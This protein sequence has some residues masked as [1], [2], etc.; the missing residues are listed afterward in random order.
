MADTET[1]DASARTVPAGSVR[2]GPAPTLTSQHHRITPGLVL[3]ALSIV[4]VLLFTAWVV[5]S[6]P[7]AALGAFHAYFV[8]PLALLLAVLLVPAG[9]RL[10][11]RTAAAIDAPWWTVIAT[12]AV[13][14]GFAWFAA[15]TH[16]QQIILRRDAGAYAQIG[17]WLAHHPRLTAVVPS[18]SFGPGGTDL[19]YNSAAFYERS[20]TIIPQFMTGWPTALAGAWWVGGWNGIFMLPAITGGCGILAISGLAARVIGAR[21]APLVALLTACAWPVL[22]VS[23]T[24]YSEPLAFLF[25]AGGMCLLTDLVM[26]DSTRDVVR[27]PALVAGLLLS[28]GELV[29]VDFDVDFAL[30]LPIIAWLWVTRRPGTLP[31][32]V[33]AAIGTA[34]GLADALFVTR[35]YIDL[36]LSSVELMV[37]LL[38][39]MA[40]ASIA[41]AL[42]ARRWGTA[43]AASPRGRRLTR[44]LP[45]AGVLVVVAVAAALLVRP[46]LT[47]DQS[48][49]DGGVRLFIANAQK[50]LGLPI[51]NNRGYAEQSLWWVSWYLGW[52]L[53]AAAGVG[54]AALVFRVLKGVE[55]RW[56]PAL[57][58]YGGSSLLTLLR[59]G[60][61]PDHPW[62][63]RR[64]VVE[65]LPGLVLFAS[66]T[67][68]R[69][70]R[71]VRARLSSALPAAGDQAPGT[72][73]AGRV[74]RPRIG[75]AVA[76]HLLPTATLAGLIALL[77]VPTV[78]AT[79]PVAAKRTEL[80]QLDAVETVCQALQPNDSV[81]MLD[82]LWIPNVRAQCR[83][84]VAQLP[85]PSHDAILKA[86]ASIR[87][88][89]RTPVIAATDAD[90]LKGQGF[91]P[92]MVVVLNTQ[93]D[94]QQLVKRPTTT[95]PSKVEFWLAR[96]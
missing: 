41:G 28:S 50:R 61:T 30:I 10:V 31:F 86:A 80:G 67:I 20:G 81:L 69:V 95:Q 27:R 11:S 26:A 96:P 58:V 1:A 71:A 87:S 24:T 34:L 21:W 42:F 52:P 47:V 25:L 78:R 77:L 89:G 93:Q 49:R 56:L 33:G 70:T 17:Y 19:A 57:L 76:V 2:S 14:V 51:E 83:L 74:R 29:R 91:T 37:A 35:P 82:S 88:V 5:A 40:G 18:S 38:V 60:I 75:R 4:P 59:P 53:I 23:Q 65:V 73:P 85:D 94:D 90:A 6:F 72:P 44:I 36:N 13:A 55:R 64:L 68:A 45:V 32:V 12:V 84:P 9:L 7:F 62:A 92:Q 54:V 3:G 66:W 39:L 46:Y 15:A 79:A 43:I 48:V 22:R 16:D 8:V 63:D